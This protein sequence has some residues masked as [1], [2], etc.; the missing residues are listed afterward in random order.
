MNVHAGGDWIAV[1]TKYVVVG[2]NGQGVELNAENDNEKNS[3]CT[4]DPF[5]LSLTYF[6][7]V[8]FPANL[9]MMP[10]GYLIESSCVGC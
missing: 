6:F 4:I 8:K 2:D 1:T 9:Y 5:S 10:C 7:L 3:I